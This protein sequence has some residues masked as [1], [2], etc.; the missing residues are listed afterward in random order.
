MDALKKASIFLQSART[1]ERDGQNQIWIDFKI[2]NMPRVFNKN[3]TRYLLVDLFTRLEEEV[4][5]WHRRILEIC[6]TMD[7]AKGKLCW[8]FVPCSKGASRDISKNGSW[9]AVD[10]RETFSSFAAD[11]DDLNEIIWQK[12]LTTLSTHKC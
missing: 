12:I 6:S 3:D 4:R 9:W 7:S 2:L 10:F 11:F 5:F 8:Y 1:T